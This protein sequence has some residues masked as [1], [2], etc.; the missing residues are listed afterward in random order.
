MQAQAGPPQAQAGVM[1]SQAGV[2][3]PQA[4]RGQPGQVP[5]MQRLQ[6]QQAQQQMLQKQL[7]AQLSPQQLAH[8]Q[9]MPVVSLS[10]SINDW[11]PPVLS[12]L[13]V[14]CWL[15]SCL[16][17]SRQAASPSVCCWVSS[18]DV[19]AHE[20]YCFPPQQWPTHVSAASSSSCTSLCTDVLLLQTVG[21]PFP[22]A[23]GP[24]TVKPVCR[25]SSSSTWGA[26]CT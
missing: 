13:L 10:P 8:L 2:G 6:Q 25:S 20:C 7:L 12:V 11:D 24:D 5:D 9:G 17:G 16:Q 19:Q 22:A 18:L 14:S 26:W 1:S 3:P 15:V 4:G 23:S 21:F